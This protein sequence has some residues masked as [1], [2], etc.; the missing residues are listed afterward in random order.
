MG[1]VGP[2]EH[3]ADYFEG[4]SSDRIFSLKSGKPPLPAPQPMAEEG[5]LWAAVPV[6]VFCLLV[7]VIAVYAL[8]LRWGV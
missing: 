3:H 6:A 2:E 7:L 1:T 8:A 5:L 4:D